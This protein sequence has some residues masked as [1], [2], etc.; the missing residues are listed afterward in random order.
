M[1]VVR[2]LAGS[3]VVLMAAVLCDAAGIVIGWWARPHTWAWWALGLGALL[4]VATS[5]YA[6]GWGDGRTFER[7]LRRRV[8]LWN[9]RAVASSS[10]AAGRSD[11]SLTGVAGRADDSQPGERVEFINDPPARI[12]ADADGP[13]FR[14]AA[15]A[16]YRDATR[17]RR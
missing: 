9:A 16:W 4:I 1:R 14:A 10:P 3:G 15:S 2:V 12:P 17:R 8:Q 11:A 13:A 5:S 7:A 6:A